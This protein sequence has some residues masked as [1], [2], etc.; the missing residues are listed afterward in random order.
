MK[1]ETN[2]YMNISSYAKYKEC[3]VNWIHRMIKDGKLPFIL[4]SG[5][6]FINFKTADL[7]N[8]K[9]EEK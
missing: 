3:S 1:I 7:E 6:K 4:I 5:V 9:K 2:D 8:S